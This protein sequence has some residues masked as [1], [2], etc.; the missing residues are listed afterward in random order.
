LNDLF[1]PNAFHRFSPRAH[2]KP[3]CGVT[4]NLAI[5]P[6]T[7]E[8]GVMTKSELIDF[9]AEK[10]SLPRKRAEEVINCVIAS[11]TDSLLREER[12]EIRGFGS[13]SIKHYKPYTGRNP[14]TG[15]P[16]HV[17]ATKSIHFKVGKELK[18]R[19]NQSA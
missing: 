15:E 4:T 6:Q 16:G 18:N 11:M 3:R 17:Q 12:I 19:V 9:F 10:N 1:L 7:L 13:F 14:K 8:G 5:N 2:A